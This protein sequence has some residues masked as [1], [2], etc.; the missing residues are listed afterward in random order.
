MSRAGSGLSSRTYAARFR[1]SLASRSHSSNPASHRGPP[2]LTKSC[3]QAPHS[4]NYDETHIN[5]PDRRRLC[6]RRRRLDSGALRD[7]RRCTMVTAARLSLAACGN[8]SS[9][10]RCCCRVAD[11]LWPSKMNCAEGNRGAAGGPPAGIRAGGIVYLFGTACPLA[12]LAGALRREARVSPIFPRC[13]RRRP[14]CSWFTCGERHM[15]RGS[16]R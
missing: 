1:L 14:S 12:R 5:L 2:T 16:G 13:A 7:I 8:G 15:P 6:Y 3:F 9:A 11:R 4:Q 10:R